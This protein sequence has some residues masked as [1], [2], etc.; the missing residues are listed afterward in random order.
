[1]QVDVMQW[2][3]WFEQDIREVA[4]V[5]KEHSPDVI[6]LQELTKGYKDQKNHDDT[7]EY[8]RREMGFYAVHQTMRV[9][10]GSDSWLQANAI[11]SRYPIISR[12]RH[13]V[14][15]PAEDD[16]SGDQYRGYL[17]ATID[18]QQGVV[19][20]AGTAQLTFG[21]PSNEKETDELVQQFMLNQERYL[22]G[23]DTNSRPDSDRMKKIGRHL[24]HAG[25]PFEQNTWTTKPHITPTYQATELDRRLD[26]VFTT[27]DVEVVKARIINTDVSDH[28]PILVTTEIK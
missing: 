21:E 23:S 6:L 16:E 14:Y 8:I 17:E 20:T 13:W 1:M 12:R 11:Y 27:P 25:P 24:V 28:L 22:F 7:V 10:E 15:E 3:V 26:Y 2:N 4:D 9:V 19:F 5:L 18:T